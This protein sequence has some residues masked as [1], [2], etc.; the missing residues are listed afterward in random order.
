MSV[1]SGQPALKCSEQGLGDTLHPKSHGP[2]RTPPEV[3]GAARG[4]AAPWWEGPLEGSP[5]SL[6]SVGSPPGQEA[7]LPP[8]SGGALSLY[9][10]LWV[11][12]HVDTM[13][14]LAS[15]LNSGRCYRELVFFKILGFILLRKLGFKSSNSNRDDL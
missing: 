8:G 4:H 7:G 5:G 11:E 2:G 10:E 1:T 14:E 9:A 6:D 15:L 12:K 13:R 3:K